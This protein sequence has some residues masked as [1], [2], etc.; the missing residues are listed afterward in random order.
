METAS[1]LVVLIDGVEVAR[2]QIG[3]TEDLALADRD[4][5]QGRDTIVGKVSSVA[6]ASVTAGVTRGTSCTFVERSWAA[7]NDAARQGRQDDDMPI[8][9]DGIAG[10][11]PF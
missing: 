11:G 5:P 1:T 10:D 9:R 4:G 7:S 2:R 3:G 6:G 8:V